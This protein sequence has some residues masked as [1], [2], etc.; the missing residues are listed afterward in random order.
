MPRKFTDFLFNDKI[1]ESASENKKTAGEFNERELEITAVDRLNL[2]FPLPLCGKFF[3]IF[4]FS[5]SVF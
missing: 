5:L 4:F 1:D 3:F 2:C